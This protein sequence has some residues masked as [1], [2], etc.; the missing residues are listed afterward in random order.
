MSVLGA[1]KRLPRTPFLY[2]RISEFMCYAT[3]G[4]ERCFPESH[5]P[6][7]KHNVI[8][9]EKAMGKIKRYLQL[10]TLMAAKQN[11]NAQAVPRISAKFAAGRLASCQDNIAANP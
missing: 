2:Q 9:I 11:A 5:A 10:T 8:T 3:G 7:V 6:A 4:M 1:A